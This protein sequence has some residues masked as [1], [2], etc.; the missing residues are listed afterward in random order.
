MLAHSEIL[1][2]VPGTAGASDRRPTL[3]A[4]RQVNEDDRMEA[5]R[6]YQLLD[7]APDKNLDE[8]VQLA[9]FL[10]GTS[11]AAVSI[12]DTSRQFLKARFGLDATELPR[13]TM[14]SISEVPNEPIRNRG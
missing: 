6:G 5:L 14:S 12:T 10:C 3:R 2:Q 4:L 1:P 11:I 9:A 13:S 8:L 7:T